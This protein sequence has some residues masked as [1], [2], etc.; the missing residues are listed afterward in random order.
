MIA[1]REG[2]VRQKKLRYTNRDFFIKASDTHHQ[3]S[4]FIEFILLPYLSY[5]FCS[6]KVKKNVVIDRDMHSIVGKKIKN[7]STGVHTPS[8]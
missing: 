6:T 4:D 2:F 8:S 5:S 7:K 3:I 1:H